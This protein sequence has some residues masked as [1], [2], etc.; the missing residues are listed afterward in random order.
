MAHPSIS[1]E[2]KANFLELLAEIGNVSKCC[3]AICVSRVGIYRLKKKNK[4]F[5]KQWE[6]AKDIA[7]A[8]LE[9][10]AWRRAFEGIA[11]PKFHQG[12]Q[13]RLA[14]TSE[15]PEGEPY[16]ETTY[17]DTLMMQRLNAE[18]PDKYQYRHKIE[19]SGPDGEIIVKVVKFAADGKE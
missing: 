7:N 19:G 12:E 15:H 13:L 2:T 9:D 16:F 18:W 17:S 4:T 1:S 6:L 3:E 8:K 10:E 14:P 11:R 5:R